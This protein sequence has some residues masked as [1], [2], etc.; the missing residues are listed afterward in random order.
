MNWRKLGQIFNFENS[1][2]KD[3]YISHAQS[4]QAVVYNDFV[5][6]YFT[7]RKKE[8]KYFIS[9]PQYVDY[10]L[11]FKAIIDYSKVEIINRGELGCFDEHGI[12]PFSPLVKKDEIWAYTSGWTRRVSVSVDSGIGLAISNDDGRYFKR[13][14]KG[15]V[16][17]SSLHEPFLV[18]DAFVRIFNEKYY[19]YYIYGEKWIQPDNTYQPE[20]VY[21]ITYATSIDGVNWQKSGKKIIMDVLNENECQALPSVIKMDNRYVMYF[22]YRDALD[23]RTNRNSAYKLGYAYSYDLENWIRDDDNCGIGLSD[24]AE[25]FDSEMMCYPNIF[26]IKDDYFLLYNGNSFGKN[27]F[28]IAKLLNK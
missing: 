13:L 11:D 1:P 15:P 26:N 18:I 28:G 21:K 25:C 9:C 4:P 6:V 7:T 16:L 5:R 22:C 27:G 12:F 2:F 8:G 23:F 24:N 14:G 10:T 19:M 3:R 17:S 20:R